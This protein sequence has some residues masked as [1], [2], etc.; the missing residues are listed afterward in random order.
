MEPYDPVKDGLFKQFGIV[1]FSLLV[2][3]A[4]IY[5]ASHSNLFS[6]QAATTTIASEL[7]I[8]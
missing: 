2:V 8:S 3:G 5:T 1:V 7:G 6:S 4:L